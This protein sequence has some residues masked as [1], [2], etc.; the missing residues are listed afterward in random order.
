MTYLLTCT[1]LCRITLLWLS[2]NKFIPALFFFLNKLIFSAPDK[3]MLPPKRPKCSPILRE[4]MR[5]R[6]MSVWLVF[7]SALE[8]SVYQG[9]F[10]VAWNPPNFEVTFFLLAS[11]KLHVIL[12]LLF[13]SLS[14]YKK[15]PP[16]F[17]PWNNLIFLRKI[18]ER[19][20]Q[21][22]VCY[23]KIQQAEMIAQ[24]RGSS[25]DFKHLSQ[26]HAHGQSIDQG[27]N[28]IRFFHCPVETGEGISS[29]TVP[30]YFCPYDFV[31]W[32]KH[33]WSSPWV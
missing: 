8:Q 14:F 18:S 17:Q 32:S 19:W 4:N 22:S 26:H 11:C 31:E 12:D 20:K 9:T 1:Y 27:K 13:T 28:N 10:K 25:W 30:F 7:N 3:Y 2:S 23:R 16:S 33:W 24:K 6:V 29:P 15:N 5:L 21:N